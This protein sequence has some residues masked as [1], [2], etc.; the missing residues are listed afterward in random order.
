VDTVGA[1]IAHRLKPERA[2][3][4]QHFRSLRILRGRP[5]P[6]QPPARRTD[7]GFTLLEVVVA[8]V[9]MAGVL[10][11]AAGFMVKSMQSSQGLD[12]RQTAVTVAR[13]GMEQVRGT[14]ATFAGGSSPLVAGRSMAPVVSAWAAAAAAGVD[15]SQTYTGSGSTSYDAHA[16]QLATGSSTGTALPISAT[17][18]VSGITYT[19]T[20]LIGTCVRPRNSG[21]CSRATTGDE[22]FRVVVRVTWLAGPSGT[23]SGSACS[24]SLTTLVDP[25]QQ[26]TYN[27]NRRPIA[28]DDPSSTNPPITVAAGDTTSVAVLDND[29]G[30]WPISGAVQIGIPPSHGTA[31]ASTSGNTVSYQAQS[32][33]SGTDTFTYSALDTSG[34]RSNA[35]TVTMT[36]LP[37]AMDDSFTTSTSTTSLAVVGNDRGS[38]TG[39]TLAVATQPSGG[40]TAAVSGSQIVF[41]APTAAG[42]ATYTFTYTVTD[43]NGLTSAPATV[44]VVVTKPAAPLVTPILRSTTPGTP[45]SVDVTP[46]V[47]STS[48]WTLS[49]SSPIATTT[50]KT[51][52]FTGQLL[53]GVYV[54][55]FTITDAWGQSATSALTVTVTLPGRPVASNGTYFLA[56]NQVST[57]SM[58]SLVSAP[59]SYTVTESAAYITVS[60]TTMTTSTLS[61]GTYSFVYTVTDAY[62]QSAN[63]TITL[64]V[65]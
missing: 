5:V 16:Y 2:P 60:G 56:K 64:Q 11:T 28:N 7:E 25:S 63:G 21:T 6:A 34:L 29:L 50:G 40:A 48:T 3:T 55:P 18:T 23:C 54:V 32:T 38:L 46:F 27:T 33:W 22:L 1:T 42:A 52:T 30:Y 61:K 36:V 31:T 51:L 62:G 17:S 4:E 45:V 8:V 9:L 10:M 35:A 26:P 65:S 37:K 44:T 12:E 15:V 49:E 20:T 39:A 43:A 13:R 59:G 57:F 24:Y 14:A 47:V 58:A 53:P 41:T 19:T